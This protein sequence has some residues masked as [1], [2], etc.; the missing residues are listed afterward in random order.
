L[1][2]EPNITVDG[3]DDAGDGTGNS[4]NLESGSE[5]FSMGN[6]LGQDI[7]ELTDNFT[8]SQK[9]DHRITVGT[10]NE[11]YKVNNLFA[12]S[13]FGVWSFSDTAAFRTADQTFN[14]ASGYTISGARSGG[15]VQPATFNSATVGL[16]AQDQWQITPKFNV[17][18]GLRVD[19]PIFFEQPTY[20]QQVI[21]DYQICF[22]AANCDQAGDTPG[23]PSGKPLWNPRVGFNWDIDGL[24]NQQLRGGWGIFT[25]NPAYV[26]MSNAY[27]NNG[28][29]LSIL[30][31]GPFSANGVAPAFSPDVDNQPKNCV[32][33]TTGAPTVGIGA[34]NFLGEV[35]LI[36]KGTKYPQVMRANI[37]YDRRLPED[38]ILTLEGM[39]NKGINDYFIV[40]RNLPEANEITGP[41]GRV[42]YGTI[43]SSGRS[44][45][46]YYDASVYGTFSG[47]A[48]ELGN[49][50]NNYSWNA[51]VSL[52]KAF[53]NSL[54]FTGA[55][56]YS[57]AKDVQSFTSSRAISN[58][59][60]GR[61]YSGSQY[62]DN[63]TLSA[64]DRT[65]K[66]TMSGTYLF[67]WQKWQTQFSLIYI[68]VS[69]TPYTYISGGS[70]GRGDL[71]GDGQN[72]NDPLY[73][74]RDVND[75]G[76]VFNSAADKQAYNDFIGQT[77]CLNKQRGTI[78]TR[79]SCRNPWQNVF[80]ANLR[81]ALP[82]F[83]NNLITLEIGVFNILN[84]LDSDW[85]II[86]T[87]G[88][89]VFPNV[90]IAR[91]TDATAGVP[92]FDYNGPTNDVSDPSTATFV[93]NG[94][95]RN[96]WQL[97]FSLRYEY[98]Q[99]IF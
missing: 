50:S 65:N 77:S 45:P 46:N 91:V 35:D 13:S 67:P 79:S 84:M 73:I 38:V 80:E 5:Q 16:Y 24:G 20:D 72:G 95:N 19:I 61:Q 92:N 12:Q 4:Y 29:G 90:N 58:W 78:M 17:T 33:A 64:F 53:G 40:D 97:Q 76:M 26:W 22:G 37:A 23:V 69:G 81:Q 30:S 41:N 68:G 82:A 7:V 83:G 57:Q 71:N 86:K 66:V 1:V 63:A 88:G 34:G 31:C 47:G 56:T 36:G 93:D 54:R 55:Y 51:T 49:T 94:D 27:S 3:F 75:P 25:G 10:R 89:G 39:Y 8:L 60:F 9:G 74:I 18:Y 15:E 59:R 62:D 48:F 96:S 87:A 11:F 28:T 32:D 6:R 21:S 44:D 99:G 14:T 2:T 43:N 52:A 42:A 85:G 98:G 70:S